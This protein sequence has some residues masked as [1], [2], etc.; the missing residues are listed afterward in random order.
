MLYVG[1]C[2]MAVGGISALIGLVKMLIDA[3]GNSI[4]WGLGILAMPVCGICSVT[5]SAPWNIVFAVAQLVIPVVYA[6]LY[7]DS[8]KRY[9]LAWLVGSIIFGAGSGFLV[10]GIAQ[11][12]KEKRVYALVK[13]LYRAKQDKKNP[14]NTYQWA[15]YLDQKIT[16]LNK[17]LATE[18]ITDD[19]IKEYEELIEQNQE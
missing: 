18:G 16:K 4:L 17:E 10:I 19:Q 12:A 3:F 1:L 15:V 11:D 7:W 13:E 2:L 9:F 8:A 14:R 5:T 6:I